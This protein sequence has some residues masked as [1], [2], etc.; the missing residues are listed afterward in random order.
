LSAAKGPG[1]IFLCGQQVVFNDDEAKVAVLDAPFLL[2]E[3]DRFTSSAL[4]EA[5][6]YIHSCVV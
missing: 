5:T 1:N 3:W 4:V 6:H 2:P